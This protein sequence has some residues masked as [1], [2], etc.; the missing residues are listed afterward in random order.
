MAGFQHHLFIVGTC[1]AV[2]L[3]RPVTQLFT[4]QYF[5]LADQSFAS[6]VLEQASEAALA[7]E[8]GGA[9]APRLTVLLPGGDATS[10]V[11]LKGARQLCS[12]AFLVL[13]HPLATEDAAL[14]HE[15]CA[16]G[17]AMYQSTV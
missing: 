6:K 1:S 17:G 8:E 2:Y 3:E 12:T 15:V 9:G 5:P 16:G 10:M 4:V 7:E 11:S 14:R 13:W